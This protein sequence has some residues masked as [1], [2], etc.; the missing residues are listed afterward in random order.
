M[1]RTTV[2]VGLFCL[3]FIFVSNHSAHA[4]SSDTLTL[5]TDPFHYQMKQLTGSDELPAKQVAQVDESKTKPKEEPKTPPPVQYTVVA[6]DTL[7]KIATTHQ[8]TVE[9]LYAKNTQIADPNIIDVSNVLVIPTTDEQLADRPL[10]VPVIATPPSSG[11]AVR[12]GTPAVGVSYS[13]TNSAGNTYA[14]GYCTWY[15]K[16]RRPDLPNRL[17]NAISWVG[18]AAA[19]GF[20]TGSTPQVGA[21]GQQG[22][23]VVYIESVNGDGTVT[24]SEMNYKGLYVVSSRTVA[25]SAFTYIY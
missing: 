5:T 16:N 11:G 6:G 1:L 23:H 17:G 4:L 10:P 19:Q 25:A 18:S 20:A 24:V 3:V 22:N 13:A 15:V 12:S 21:V 8:T 14:P 9:R 2:K 7:T